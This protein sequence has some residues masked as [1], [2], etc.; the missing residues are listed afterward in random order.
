M[1]MIE[2]DVLI[3]GAGPTGASLALF[4][5]ENNVSTVLIEK[6]S[7]IDCPLRCAE[8]VTRKIAGLFD[9]RIKGIDNRI[10]FMDTY[11]GFKKKAQSASPGFMLNREIFTRDLAER[12]IGAGGRFFASFRLVSIG[13]GTGQGINSGSL[14]FFISVIEGPGRRFRVKSKIVVG[15][16]GPLSL[17][18]KIM[19]SRNNR[20]L[21]GYQENIAA[22]HFPPDR[23]LVFFAPFIP[24]GYGW[25]FPKSESIN[26]GIGMDT[27]GWSK[28]HKR[29]GV[30]GAAIREAFNYFKEAV[31]PNQAEAGNLEYKDTGGITG[32]IPVSGMVEKP[33]SG[34]LVLVGDAAGLCHPI[35]GA[36]IY[37]AVYSSKIA[38]PYI[39]GAV[40]N[41]CPAELRGIKEAYISAWG[42]SLEAAYR[43]RKLLDAAEISPDMASRAFKQLVKKTWIAFREYW[44]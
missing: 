20:F 28:E 32:L 23:A 24:G 4:L 8:L 33:V 22:R 12:F 18:G 44:S 37:N 34:G 39:T 38:A 17:V 5:A 6:K 41:G 43:N 42:R 15:A 2:C 19:G 1:D 36:G 9:F 31:F 16:D 29:P 13:P 11:I 35:T 40:A 14:P 30:K 21:A 7:R 27:A 25:L 3:V 10:D 26:L